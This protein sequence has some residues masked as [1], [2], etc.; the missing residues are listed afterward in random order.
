M[1]EHALVAL[2]VSPVERPMIACLPALKKWGLKRVTLLHVMTKVD[3]KSGVD[4][5]TLKQLMDQLESNFD[6]ECSQVK[7]I[8]LDGKACREIV[9]YGRVTNNA[10]GWLDSL[11]SLTVFNTLLPLPNQR[12]TQVLPVL[13]NSGVGQE[14]RGAAP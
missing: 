10:D 5:D 3:A 8:I 13:A 14:P 12:Y 2:D 6:R 1:F 11:I 4:I 9:R 7:S